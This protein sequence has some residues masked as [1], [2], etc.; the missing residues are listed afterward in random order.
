[1]TINRRQALQLAG[2]AAIGAAPLAR[3]LGQDKGKAPKVLFFTK[4]SGPEHSVI[5]RSGDKLAHAERILTELAKEHGFEIECSKDGRVFEP[6]NIGQYDLFA[7]ETTG[8]LSKPGTDKAPPISPE[9]EAALYSAVKAGKGFVGFHCAT[10]TFGSHRKQGKEDPYIAMIGAE[11]AGHGAQQVATLK[12][13]DQAFPGAKP[14]GETFTVNDEW[15]A[16]KNIADD[17]HVVA[18]YKTEGMKGKEYQRPDYPETWA[19]LHGKGRVFYT[20]M[21]HREDVWENKMFH[22]LIIG[23][24]FWALGKLEAD[25]TPNITT[26]TPK[27]MTMPA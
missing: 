21:G 10:D 8:D 26:A 18:A 15:Y 9:G 3:A 13:T 5:R 27:Y 16:L 12:I 11:F 7:F 2:A 14:L 19:R 1:M 6:A 22:S 20:S 4:S 24:M 17:L 23:G 25:V